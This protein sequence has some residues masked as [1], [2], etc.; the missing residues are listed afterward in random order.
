MILVMLVGILRRVERDG[1][2]Y[3]LGWVALSRQLGD[4][5]EQATLLRQLGEWITL[6]S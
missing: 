3:I 4:M 5:L 2:H 1:E 6:S